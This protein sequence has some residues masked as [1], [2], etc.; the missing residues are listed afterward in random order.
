MARVGQT[1]SYRFRIANRGTIAEPR[2]VVRD[3]LPRGVRFVGASAS[4]GRCSYRVA[5]RTVVCNLGRVV[6]D[7]GPAFMT[8]RVRATRPGLARNIAMVAGAEVEYDPTNNRAAATTRILR[9]SAP[10]LTGGR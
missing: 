8:I 5:T 2:T 1:F 9:A 3:R 6:D 10:R 7:G 4:Q